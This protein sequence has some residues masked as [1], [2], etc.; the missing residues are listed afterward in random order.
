MTRPQDGKTGAAD[1]RPYR[2]STRP[3]STSRSKC[4]GI[5]RRLDGGENARIKPAARNAPKSGLPGLRK[6]PLAKRHDGRPLGNDLRT[7]KVI[8]RPRRQR[9]LEGCAKSSR[10]DIRIDQRTQRERDAELLRSRLER[11]N[12]GREMRS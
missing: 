10:D 4:R 7:Q 3:R 2:A 1:A 6:Q 11:K 8:R 12:V 5:S 9:D